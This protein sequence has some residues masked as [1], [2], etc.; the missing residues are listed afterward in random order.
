MSWFWASFGPRSAESPDS[1]ASLPKVGPT[2][3]LGAPDAEP[4]TTRV[5]AGLASE[6]EPVRRGA[7][8]FDADIMLALLAALDTLGILCRPSTGESNAEENEVEGERRYWSGGR[9]TGIDP[10]APLGREVEDK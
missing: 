3:G 8:L 7:R 4:G 6:I 9:T 5:A 1:R 2:S 10:R